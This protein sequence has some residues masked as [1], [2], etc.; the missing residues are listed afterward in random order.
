MNVFRR[1][2]DEE[3][4]RSGDAVNVEGCLCYGTASIG[5]WQHTDRASAS[6]QC[7]GK[8]AGKQA[9]KQASKHIV[10][11]QSKAN[12]HHLRDRSTDMILRE[13]R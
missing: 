9:S 4:L 8:R 10:N 1:M 13:Q 2:D 3:H 12:N 11:K 5:I 6:A 7:I